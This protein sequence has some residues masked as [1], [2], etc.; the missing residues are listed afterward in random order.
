[1]LLARLDAV[2]RG[3]SAI[4]RARGGL[5]GGRVRCD[6]PV[7]RRV[8]VVEHFA[9]TAVKLLDA[10]P[11]LVKVDAQIVTNVGPSIPENASDNEALKSQEEGN[12]RPVEPLGNPLL[13][14]VLAKLGHV[15]RAPPRRKVRTR[16]ACLAVD[17]RRDAERRVVQVVCAAPPTEVCASQ[18]THIG[19]E[20]ESEIEHA[21]EQALTRLWHRGN[22]SCIFLHSRAET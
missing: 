6:A 21:L 2:S 11:M 15:V 3:E 4:E 10:V 19:V 17:G 22:A 9:G 20:A 1:M 12:D 5:E 8:K 7:A 16:E 14:L 13:L 18:Y